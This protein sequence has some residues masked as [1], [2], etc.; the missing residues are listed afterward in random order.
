MEPTIIKKSD[1]TSL[2]ILPLFF[3]FLSVLSV[4]AQVGI[5]TVG[6]P[7]STLEVNGSFAQK[8]TTITAS[9]TLTIDNG[10]VICN[11]GATAITVT[12]PSPVGISGRIYTI[13]RNATSSAN[14]TIAGTINGATNLILTAAG[15][16]ETLFSD[17][18]EWKSLSKYEAS[19]ST[20]WSLTGNAGTTPGTN[21]IGTTDTQDLV[22]KTNN[23]SRVNITSGGVT[24]IGD[25]IDGGNGINDTKIEADGT[26]MFEGNATVWDDLRV[27]PDAGSSSATLGYLPGEA[28]GG[29]IYYFRDDKDLETLTFQVQLPHSYKE[30]TNIYPHIHW[31]PFKSESG[32]VEWN[33]DYTWVNYDSG[34]PLV[35]PATTTSTVVA[36]GPFTLRTHLIASLTSGGVGLDGTN[37]KVSS[38]LICRI[39]R[40]SRNAADTYQDDAGLLSL[41][42][43]FQIDTV[44][45]RGEFT[46]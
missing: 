20:G 22:L 9:T 10:I 14:V 17:N 42:F 45:S 38:I 6:D 40:D 12:L 30:G 21:Y 39:W 31:T 41:D 24:T 19:S 7:T 26:I 18:A 46:K 44:G 5:N 33:L 36:T 27:A 25:I 11:N 15:Q 37:K 34:T 35:F 13:K 32:N 23:T 29:Q 1:R 4:N 28:S 3:F 43:H 8:V 2:C 16:A